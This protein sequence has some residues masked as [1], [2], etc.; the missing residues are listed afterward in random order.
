MA[1]LIYLSIAEIFDTIGDSYLIYEND[2]E[3][4]MNGKKLR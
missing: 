3:D 4:V 1:S 2:V